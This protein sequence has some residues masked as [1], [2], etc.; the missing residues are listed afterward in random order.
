MQARRYE[1]L[2]LLVEVGLARAL[3]EA[4][5]AAEPPCD[6]QRVLPLLAALKEIPCVGLGAERVPSPDPPESSPA[7]HS[8]RRD[9]AADRRGHDRAVVL[10]HRGDHE[11]GA[12]A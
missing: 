7:S 11:A 2:G 5:R 3:A 9:V 6:E 8:V 12:L 10:E 4:Q 1:S